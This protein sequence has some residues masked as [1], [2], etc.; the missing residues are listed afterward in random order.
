MPVGNEAFVAIGWC[1]A[2][3]VIGRLGAAYL[4]AR[5]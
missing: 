3:I 5:R 1:V 4:F 2:G